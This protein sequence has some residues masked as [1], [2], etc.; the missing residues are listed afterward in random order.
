MPRLLRRL[1]YL[2]H[3]RRLE[4]ELAEEIDAHRAMR[5]QTLEAHGLTRNEAERASRRALGNVTLAR[6]DA[7]AAWIAPWIESVWQDVVYALRIVRRAPAF[8]AAIVLVMALGIGATTGVFGLLDDLVLKDLPVHRPDRLVYFTKPSFSYPVLREVAARGTHVFSSVAG[9]NLERANIEWAVELEPAEILAATGNFYETLGI[10]AAAGRTFGPDDDQMG[11][12]A[13]GPVAV[14]SHAC[15]QRRFGASRS[16]IGRTVRIDRTP[17]TIVGVTPPGFSGVAPGLAPE[18]TIPWSVLQNAETLRSHAT[19]SIHLLGRLREGLTLLQA[20]AALQAFWPSVLEVTTPVSM[21]P[22]RR[23]MYLSRSTQ[24]HSARAGYSRVRNQFEEPLWML[25]ALVGLLMTV[26]CASAANLLLA[27]GVARRREIAVRLAIGAGRGRLVRQMLTEAAVWTTLAAGLGIGLAS[28]SGAALVA[29]MTTR[30]EPIVIDVTPDWRMLLFG[31]ALAFLA[32]GFCALVPAFR[33]T[34]L[35]PGPTLKGGGT[36]A[37]LARRW[38][39]GKTLVAVQIAL[40]IV[41]LVGAGLFVRSLLRV[42]AQDA[43][44]DR[45]RVLVLATDPKA[46]GYQAAAL[47]GYY[48]RLLERLRALPGVEAA[49]LSWYPPISDQDGMWSQSIAVDGVPLAPIATRF[50]YF[51]AISPRY[52]EALGMRIVRGR[53]FAA[54]DSASAP[55]VVAVNE[56]LARRFFPGQ[57]PLGRRITIGRNASRRDLEIVAIVSDAKYQRLQ[58]EPRSI[59]YLPCAQLGEMIAGENLHAEVRTAASMAATAQQMR[60]AAG[61]LDPRVPIRVETVDDRIRQS[62]VRER[63]IAFLASGLGAAAL[64]LACAGLYGLLAYAVSRQTYEIGLR[65]ALGAN[66]RVVLWL[67]LRECL[68]LALLGTAAGLAASLALGRA[69]RAFLRQLA[70]FDPVSPTDWLALAAATAVMIAVAA[71]AGLVPARRAAQVDPAVALRM[72]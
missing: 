45:H 39:L 44:F 70:P 7:R 71:L 26:A 54:G 15:W 9:W 10:R 16:A 19:S 1:R 69:V 23:A 53:D 20:D 35:D 42:L 48:D 18:V 6:E 8:A 22:D 13:Q 61:D 5:Q 41:L 30:D 2:I 63:I 4:A 21:P 24:L 38:S 60:R 68:V 67:V 65:L 36:A 50:V 72:E 12:G 59:A 31:L 52:F 29:M 51:N 3:Q 46:A 56:S 11:G 25:L 49:A 14:I 27:R 40:T 64:T 62:L 57:D 47:A 66:R 43:G 55:R 32:A 58:E 37:G 34:R 33:S 17:F 28:W